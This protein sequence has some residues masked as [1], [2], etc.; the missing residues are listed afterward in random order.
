MAFATSNTQ[1][2]SVGSL[3]FFAG[4]WSGAAGDASGTVTVSGGR[5][6]LAS[7]SDQDADNPKDVGCAFDVSASGTTITITVHN[8]DTV[9][10]G[11]FLLIY[12]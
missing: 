6:Y 12:A 10:N 8:H 2:G 11:R 3:K 7:F 5:I 1:G 4:D 9:T